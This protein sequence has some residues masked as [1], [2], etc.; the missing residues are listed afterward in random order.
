MIN[1]SVAKWM[2]IDG[3]TFLRSIGI[4]PGQVILDFGCGAG[5]YAIPASKLVG[6]DGRIYAMDE[7]APTLEKLKKNIEK[8]NIKNIV[9]I[10]GQSHIPLKHDSVD[11][12]LCYDVI[13]FMDTV[14]RKLF[15]EETYRVLESNGIFSVYPKH[16][17]EDF[18]LMKLA[19]VELNDIIGE[20]VQSGLSLQR[21]FLAEVLHD[22]YYDTGYLLN[23][24]KGEYHAMD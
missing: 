10:N 6:K 16:H 12:V 20:V 24:R 13:H 7:S 18:P 15:Y 17:K 23:F 8:V 14:E 2:N 11:A 19:N 9:L 1:K 5:H 3:Q 22:D 4:K 21:K